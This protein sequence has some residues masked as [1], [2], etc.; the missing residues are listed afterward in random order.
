MNFRTAKRRTFAGDINIAPLVDMVF[1]LLIF[2]LIS[3][4]F[5]KRE[6]AFVIDLPT[7]GHE[8]VVVRTGMDTI[9]V[10]REGKIFFLEVSKDG[11]GD[12]KPQEFS[13]E[14]LKEKLKELSGKDPETPISIRGE[15]DTPLQ[16]L[17]NALDACY[18]A[19]LKQIQLP[20][21]VEKNP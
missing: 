16:K 11:E 19:G 17:M 5:K 15:K 10:T 8:E 13:V 14:R 20:Y 4:T 2:L 7:A 12:S 6:H 21:E 18:E 1:L 3:T 9:F